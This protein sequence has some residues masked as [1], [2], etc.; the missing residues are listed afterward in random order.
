MNYIMRETNYDYIMK[1]EQ[2]LNR[3][4]F[5]IYGNDIDILQ[6]YN[7]IVV[8]IVNEGCYQHITL[9]RDWDYSTTTSKH[10]YAFLDEYSKV[11]IYSVSNKRKYV[12][13]LIKECETNRNDFLDKHGYSISYDDNMV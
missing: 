7:S 3:N 4:Q 11:R 9:G 5:H 8:K 12:R 1:V 10:V 13:D 6:S 2:F